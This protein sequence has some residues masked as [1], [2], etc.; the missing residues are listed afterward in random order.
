M[1]S[2]RKKRLIMKYKQRKLMSKVIRLAANCCNLFSKTGDEKVQLRPLLLIN[3]DNHMIPTAVFFNKL[4]TF[5]M[6][7]A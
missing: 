2:G 1:N 7:A 6:M 4:S 5:L 3:S